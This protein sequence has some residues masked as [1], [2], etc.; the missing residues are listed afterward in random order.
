MI[1]QWENAS[2]KHKLGVCIAKAK[3]EETAV[4]K[5]LANW[6]NLV[7]TPLALASQLVPY[8]YFG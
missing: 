2:R 4:A 8:F 7:R 1:V 5:Q 3:V 6:H